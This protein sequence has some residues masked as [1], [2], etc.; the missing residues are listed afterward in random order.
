[1]VHGDVDF[2]EDGTT[3]SFKGYLQ[4]VH[5]LLSSPRTHAPAYG[6][7]RKRKVAC[8]MNGEKE[9]IKV[10]V[11]NKMYR[12]RVRRSSFHPSVFLYHLLLLLPFFFLCCFC[13]M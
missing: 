7:A 5:V 12:Y 13:Y 1:M 6:K 8:R 2:W 9:N 11:P 3:S 4:H 10:N